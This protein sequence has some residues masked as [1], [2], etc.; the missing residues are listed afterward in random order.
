MLIAGFLLVL[1]GQEGDMPLREAYSLHACVPF[2]LLHQERTPHARTAGYPHA[3]THTHTHT[4]TA[5]CSN[6]TRSHLGTRARQQ[7]GLQLRKATA[8]GELGEPA[9]AVAAGARDA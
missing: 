2:L 3:H 4:H 6:L 7:A 8:D 1:S 5:G 9:E